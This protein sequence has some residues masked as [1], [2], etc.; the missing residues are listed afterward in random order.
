MNGIVAVVTA[1]S[2]VECSRIEAQLMSFS[3][4]CSIVLPFPVRAHRVAG[5]HGR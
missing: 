5:R 2:R 4:M 3:V 1:C